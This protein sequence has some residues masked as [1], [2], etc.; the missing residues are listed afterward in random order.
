MDLFCTPLQ[1][2]SRNVLLI[3]A[4]YHVPYTQELTN[5][6]IYEALMSIH[7]AVDLVPVKR[8]NHDGLHQ[9]QNSLHQFCNCMMKTLVVGMFYWNLSLCHL[10]LYMYRR[11]NES[12]LHHV[13]ISHKLTLSIRT[14]L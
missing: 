8:F 3:E 1:L 7:I 5:N 11:G 4:T 12:L 9:L 10:C 13:F 2:K 14:D 6:P